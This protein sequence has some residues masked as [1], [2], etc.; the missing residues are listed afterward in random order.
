MDRV[1]NSTLRALS[2]LADGLGMA[3]FGVCQPP[4]GAVLSGR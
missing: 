3:E 4:A 2:E 1:A